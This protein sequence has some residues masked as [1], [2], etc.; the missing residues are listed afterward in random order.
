MNN[1]V[2]GSVTVTAMPGGVKAIAI[3]EGD[4]V[5]AV[6]ERSGFAAGNSVIRVN[7]AIVGSSHELGNG[8]RVTLTEQIKGN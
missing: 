2:A 8:D 5:G 1:E 3:N 6:I 4:T 7:G